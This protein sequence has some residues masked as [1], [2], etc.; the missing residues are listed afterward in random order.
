MA[1]KFLIGQ[2]ACYGDC[3]YATTVAKQIRNDFPDSHITWAVASKYKSILLLNPDVDAIWEVPINNND[4]YAEG[5]QN[6]LKEAESRQR[7]G[8]YDELV[9]TQIAPRWLYYD[10]V[11][12]S[13]TIG[14]YPSPITVSV[15]PVVRLSDDEISNVKQFTQRAGLGKFRNVVLVEYAPGSGQSFMN[16]DFALAI[17]NKVIKDRG[18]TC[19]VLTGPTRLADKHPQIV[20]ASGLTYRENAE[21]TKYC[22]LLVGCSSGITWL[23]T[24]DWA[25]KLDMLQVL[26]RQSVFFAGIKYD[27]DLWGISTANV[28]ETTVN[29]TDYVAECVN[30]VLKDGIIPA[31]ERYDEQYKP[32]YFNYRGIV[33]LVLKDNGTNNI[34]KLPGI[35]RGYQKTNKHLNLI[36][37]YFIAGREVVEFY[38]SKLLQHISGVPRRVYNK[39]FKA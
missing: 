27:F 6:F 22:N 36:L 9:F 1:K 35:I 7:A 2:L 32:Q 5:W 38:G 23:A 33:K 24:S 25:K 10:G 14:S 31:K 21:L 34:G 26:D 11:I 3:L 12:R 39:L 19:F 28:V 16:L 29:S 13:S 4:F 30:V 17:A 8:I 20:D 18:D 15:D 37:L